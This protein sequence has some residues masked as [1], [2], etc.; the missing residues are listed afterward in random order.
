MRGVSTLAEV[1]FQAIA[2]TP[3]SSR[4]SRRFIHSTRRHGFLSG[5]R[6]LVRQMLVLQLQRAA[7]AEAQFGSCRGPPG[8]AWSGRAVSRRGLVLLHLEAVEPS[9]DVHACLLSMCAPSRDAGV[10]DLNVTKRAECEARHT[11]KCF[12]ASPATVTMS[13]CAAQGAASA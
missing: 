6:P 8:S 5:T 3:G 9:R 10:L 1:W 4:K 2:I 7:G 12:C 13:S 11:S